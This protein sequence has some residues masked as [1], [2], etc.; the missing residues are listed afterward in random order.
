MLV[1]KITSKQ[2]PLVKRFRKLRT[3][4]E[5]SL[6]LIEGVRMMEEAL[7]AGVHFES[8]AFTTELESTDRGLALQDELQHVPCRGALLSKQV[9]DYISDTE[10]PQGVAAMVARPTFTLADV[11]DATP[12]LT[13]IADGIQD[14]GN[15]GAIVRVAE[16]AGA[17]GLVALPGTTSPF[18]SKAVRASMGSVLRLPV[19]I[20][21]KRE[22]VTAIARENKVALVAAGPARP[23]PVG[24]ADRS[25][26]Y[27]D[28]DYREP[29]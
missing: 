9:M 5:R 19:A 7:E 10:S 11:F 21:T 4:G 8:I 15:M 3:G 12:Q 22:D 16:A 20:A 24:P 23:S 14:P 29:L 1:E 25:R 17:T 18:G 26:A 27:T 13:V 2:N 6:I 28:A